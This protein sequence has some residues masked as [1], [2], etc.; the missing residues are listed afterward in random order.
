[1]AMLTHPDH[2][3]RR[4]SPVAQAAGAHRNARLALC[5]HRCHHCG[6]ISSYYEEGLVSLK[7]CRVKGNRRL[8]IDRHQQGTNAKDDR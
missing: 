3:A 6:S 2:P 8:C 1:M 7:I 5:P 4:Q